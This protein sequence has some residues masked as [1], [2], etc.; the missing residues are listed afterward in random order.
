MKKLPLSVLTH[1][2]LGCDK[3]GQRA[4]EVVDN[5]PGKVKS[6]LFLMKKQV[7]VVS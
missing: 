2:M 1:F 6:L 5:P 3:K 4:L 7:S